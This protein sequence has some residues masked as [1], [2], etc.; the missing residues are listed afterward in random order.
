[1]RKPGDDSFVN[2][3][4][5]SLKNKMSKTVNHLID[6]IQHSRNEPESPETH[7]QDELDN[8]NN[9]VH[10]RVDVQNGVVTIIVDIPEVDGENVDV[11]AKPTHVDVQTFGSQTTQYDKE[12]VLP[13]PVNI[14]TGDAVFNNG[15]LEITF[16][17][18][19]EVDEPPQTN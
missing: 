15:I 12:I 8:T 3:H 10:T 4:V 17:E 1:M 6:E 9:N 5:E 13:V 18:Q 14:K 7:H 2:D 16:D 19:T 11:S